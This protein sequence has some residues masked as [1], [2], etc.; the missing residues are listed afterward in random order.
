MALHLI[1]LCVGVTT[2]EEQRD[3]AK[4]RLAFMRRLDPKARLFHT[5]RMVPKRLD[6]VLDGGS[7]YWVIKGQVQARQKLIDI[8]PFVDAGGTRRCH[9]VLDDEIIPTLWQPKR[10]FQ[11]WR[12]FKAEDAPQDVGVTDQEIPQNLRQELG[13]LGL[14]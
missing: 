14:L 9:L 10:A 11:G 3:W 2:L 7:L 1:K 12:Y 6:E 4:R 13:E 8:E 5:T